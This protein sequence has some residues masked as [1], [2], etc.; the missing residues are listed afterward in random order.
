MKFKTAFEYIPEIMFVKNFKSVCL[1]ILMIS[2]D[3]THCELFQ[4][5][6]DEFRFYLNTFNGVI[7]HSIVSNSFNVN[8]LVRCSY[9]CTQ[10]SS[11]SL[12]FSE[13][14]SKCYC[15]NGTDTRTEHDPGQPAMV[16]GYFEYQ[17]KV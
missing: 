5:V 11:S 16:Y 15:N 3:A 1:F 17:T 2:F 14:E 7:D 10:T 12:Y 6:K 9:R 13:N 4:Y 8:S